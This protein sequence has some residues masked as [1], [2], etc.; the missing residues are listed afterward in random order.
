[1]TSHEAEAPNILA[2]V[3][4]KSKGKFKKSLTYNN[5]F[6]TTAGHYITIC[7]DIL[8]E[9]SRFIAS[10]SGMIRKFYAISQ[11]ANKPATGEYNT[12]NILNFCS[13][14][15]LRLSKNQ[16]VIEAGTVEMQ[17]SGTGSGGTRNISGTNPLHNEL[18]EKL[19][20]FHGKETAVLFNSAYVA[21]V[22]ALYSLGKFLENVTF[23]S[24]SQNHASI[25]HGINLSKASKVI[26]SHNNLD[27]LEEKLCHNSLS[28]SFSKNRVIVCESIYSM[29]GTRTNIS[30][31]VEIAK[32]HQCLIYLDEVHAIGIY[33]S[34]RGI[35]FE[36]GLSHEID[37]INGT[38]GKAVGCVGGYI[39][40][41]SDIAQFVKLNATTFIFSTSLPP[42]VCASALRS[43]EVIANCDDL[44]SQLFANTNFVKN[45]LKARNIQSLPN[46]SHIIILPI[47]SI[48]KVKLISQNLLQLHSIYIQ[49]IFYPT[50]R[51]GDELLRITLC[52]QNT[53]EE[54]ELLVEKLNHELELHDVKKSIS[55]VAR[56]SV[57]SR[58]QTEA[59]ISQIKKYYPQYT[60]EESYISTFGDSNTHKPI[61]ELEFTNAFTKEIEQI[62]LQG[63]NTIGVS[64][65]KDIEIATKNG[66]EVECFLERV[67]P[68][69]VLILNRNAKEKISQG[70]VLK[71]GTSSIRRKHLFKA[72]YQKI[73]PNCTS[74]EIVEIRGNIDTRIGRLELNASDEGYLD[75][76]ILA[77]AGLIRL[78]N[79]ILFQKK[80]FELTQGKTFIMLPI[81]KFPTPPG[82][83][84]IACQTVEGF[85]E[86]FQKINHEE[87]AE[88]VKKEKK[89]FHQHG[90]GCRQGFG[91]TTLAL[92]NHQCSFVKGITDDGRILNITKQENINITKED[93]ASMCDS[94]KF[95]LYERTAIQFSIPADAKRFFVASHHVITPQTIP[96]LQNA[97]EVWASGFKTHEVLS[98]NGILC[99]GSVES[100]GFDELHAIRLPLDGSAFYTLTYQSDETINDPFTI[101]TYSMQL[102]TNSSYYKQFCKELSNA[103]VVLWVSLQLYKDFS[104]LVKPNAKHICML[105]KTYEYISQ[106]EKKENIIG[107]FNFEALEQHI[108]SVL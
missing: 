26:Y 50:V 61:H 66:I 7:M 22:G 79:S 90:V 76:V 49:P 47:N 97:E 81:S 75:G 88:I 54:L 107:I 52:P 27:E 102:E 59:F 18:E 99:N 72:L 40:T 82:Q 71:I 89:I 45:E 35:A 60:I 92:K 65:L 14:D 9:I 13:N 5:C 19:A 20:I 64:S 17:K 78:K 42:F 91:V 48:E 41:T 6:C 8:N 83:G 56:K 80:Y 28:Q 98:K 53:K 4:N 34:G 46:N 108:K 58:A 38:L 77:A 24:D 51:H 2:K 55:V 86:A 105:G 103:T 84:V 29:T 15:Y 100:L 36:D 31:L 101:A 57:L 62:I 96:F 44:R 37:I 25:I 104:H 95:S 3:K 73:L 85:A 87:T 12:K 93:I 67:N 10:K 74:V 33:G 1:M 16:S 68:R 43:V 32:K 69:D 70:A 21:N 11:N 94:R 63:K 30:R 106:K 23:F 39:S